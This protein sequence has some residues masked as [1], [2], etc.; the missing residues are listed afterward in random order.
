[1]RTRHPSLLAVVFWAST[2]SGALTPVV[3]RQFAATTPLPTVWVVNTPNGSSTVRWSADHRR[4]GGQCLALDYRFTG[5]GQYLGVV[6]PVRI[7]A[8]VHRLHVWVDGQT[9]ATAVGVYLGD[10]SGETHKF[11][12]EPPAAGQA[13]W[14]EATVDL[15]RP[16]ESWGGDKNG[17]ID[18]PILA[19]TFE[20]SHPGT[21]PAAGTLRFADLSVDSERPAVQTL[22]VTIAVRSPPYGADVRGDTPVAVVAPGFDAVTATCWQ[23]GPGGGS[24]A[25][26]ATCPLDGGGSGSFVFPADRFPHGPVTVRI[27]GHAGAVSDNCYLQLYN[28][29]G[30]PWDE[31]MPKGPPPAAAG[32]RLAFADDF[33]R[34]PSIS[35]TDGRATYFDHKPLGGDFSSLPFTGHAE[36]G[37]PFRQRDTYLR[38][39]ADAKRNSAGLISSEFDDGHGVKASAPCY[40]E[41]RF[42]GPNAIGTWPAFWLM[43][44]YPAARKGG[45]PDTAPCDE[46]DVIEGYGG[47]GLGEPNSLDRYNVTPHAW[48]QGKGAEATANAAWAG[49]H[50]PVSMSHFGIPSTWFETAHVYGCRV[51]EAATTYYCDDVEV[52]RHP[53]LAVC[54][55]EPLFFM[56]NLATGGG[57][58]VDLS[59][60]DGRADMY[61]DYVRVYQGQR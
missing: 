9:P 48:N 43:T 55:R 21:D 45:L 19:V 44:D 47:E 38:I 5:G 58:P 29:G 32:M 13:G 23:R 39:R 41:C 18:Y 6:N 57:W 26:V 52:G 34:P 53:T 30:R 20:V 46:L 2:A 12:F 51:T 7:L 28:T 54:K 22:G 25:A 61:V 36:P 17:K 10:V 42:V 49:L 24:R 11:R 50:S 16:H 1:M 56:V 27:G 31:G 40:F 14:R 4:A 60:Y 59:R 37:D 3:V 35:T 15:D 8:A 33:D